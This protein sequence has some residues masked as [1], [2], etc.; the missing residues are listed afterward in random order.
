MGVHEA[1]LMFLLREEV[2][3]KYRAPQA[4]RAP[5][6]DCVIKELLELSDRCIDNM[7]E[8]DRLCLE[9][10]KLQ[11][12]IRKLS[13]TSWKERCFVGMTVVVFCT[14]FLVRRQRQLKS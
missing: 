5:S 4:P 9:I 11:F 3:G 2:M 12:T 13:Q 6:K 14:V 8:V 10:S 7:L 1:I